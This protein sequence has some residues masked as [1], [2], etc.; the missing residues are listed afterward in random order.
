M[1]VT[2]FKIG[3]S[4]RNLPRSLEDHTEPPSSSR[5][6]WERDVFELKTTPSSRLVVYKEREY[7]QLFLLSKDCTLIQQHALLYAK[8]A[9]FLNSCNGIII[10]DDYVEKF[11][12]QYANSW[13]KSESDYSLKNHYDLQEIQE[14]QYDEEEDTLIY[15]VK[16]ANGGIPRKVIFHFPFDGRCHSESRPLPVIRPA[17]II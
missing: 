17:G 16:L 5:L 3:R 15:Y 14:P 9:N 2:P 1:Y 13:K 12:E 7:K 6:R 11:K 4:A 8:L 10:E